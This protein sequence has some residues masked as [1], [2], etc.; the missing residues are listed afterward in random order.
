MKMTAL[1]R[2]LLLVTGLLAAYQVAVGVNGL[3]TLPMIAYSTSFG[4]LL[5]A[6]LL[7]II[8]GFDILDSPVVVI[9]ATI[10]PLALALGLVW[11]YL[12]ALRT[13]YLVFTIIGFFAVLLTRS[14]SIES[15][16][17][18]FVSGLC[19]W[20]CRVDDLPPADPACP[21]RG[22]AACLRA[23]RGGWCAD[24]RRRPAAVLLEGG[25]TCPF[26]RADL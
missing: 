6:G 21:A 23:G 13:L 25:Q 16:L 9:V 7:L 20:Y 11:Q 17:P 12:A 22:D 24:W 26:G 19:A 14:I 5:V 1:D 10:I 4:V 3:S 8:L 18:T 15:R 2:I